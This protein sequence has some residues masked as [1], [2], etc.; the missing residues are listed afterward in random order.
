MRHGVESERQPETRSTADMVVRPVRVSGLAINDERQGWKGV[1][2]GT[3][4]AR[5][6]TGR[7]PFS[8]RRVIQ[9]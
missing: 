6:K 1:S 5:V 2:M 8:S 3:R 4:E 7:A 9:I